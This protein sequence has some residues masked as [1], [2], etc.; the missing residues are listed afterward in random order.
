MLFRVLVAVVLMGFS[1]ALFAGDTWVSASTLKGA[2]QATEADLSALQKE[3]ATT[4]IIANFEKPNISAVS[5]DRRNFLIYD[6]DLVIDGNFDCDTLLVVRGNLTVNGL[7]YDYGGGIGVLVVDGQMAAKHLYSW[8]GLYVKRD[9]NVEGLAMAVYNDFTFEVG[10][11]VNARALVISDKSNDYTAGKL[12]V[13]LTD[14]G[15]IEQAV[16]YFVPEVFTQVDHFEPAFDDDFY[17]LSFDNDEGLKRMR[18]GL[19]LFRATPAAT[20]LNDSVQRV[21]KSELSDAQLQALMQQDRLLAQLISARPKLSDSLAKSLIAL[22]DPSINAWLAGSKPELVRAQSTDISPKLAESLAKNPDT[23]LATIT[24]LARHSSASV[25]VAVAQYTALPDTDA[26]RALIIALF[27]DTDAVVR[28]KTIAAFGY[29]SGFGLTLDAADINARVADSDADVRAASIQ[30]ALSAKQAQVLLGG[31][32][33][34]QR[35]D[36][37]AHVREQAEQRVPTRMTRAEITALAL[38]M[39]VT[40]NNLSDAQIRVNTEALLALPA[41]AQIL[42]LPKLLAAKAVDL[43]TVARA[44]TSRSVMRQ[45]AQL[46]LTQIKMIPQSLASNPH[47]PEDLQLKIVALARG[48]KAKLENDYSDHP[49]DALEELLGNDFAAESALNEAVDMAIQQGIAPDDGGFQNALFHSRFLPQAAIAKLDQKRN[50]D[51]DW[52]LTLMLQTHATVAQRVRALKRWYDDDADLQ[53]SLQGGESLSQAAFYERAARSASKNLQEV[54]VQNSVLPLSLVKPLQSSPHEEI[55]RAARVHP[56]I[57]LKQLDLTQF[58]STT[59]LGYLLRLDPNDWLSLSQIWSS[60]Y[61]RAIAYR[62]YGD[63]LLRAQD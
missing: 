24:Q 58:K 50:G 29:A 17:G 22:K 10:S 25:R 55:Q 19:P 35:A 61:F 46:A 48:A 28:A 15:G 11:K 43:D 8:G 21:M 20:N 56:Q 42:Q 33:V 62:R 37:A 44:S 12:D 53:Q 16:R 34:E 26:G 14:D 63:A 52:A 47:V 27:N 59:D 57:P 13:E 60:T 30:L 32:S 23:S 9:L 38:Q 39:L 7:Y 41:K 51:E 49:M 1:T 18:E 5:P 31:L 45:I 3:L 36:F 4:Q 6:G 2:R 54:A 40:T